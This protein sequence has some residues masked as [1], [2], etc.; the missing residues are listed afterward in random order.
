MAGTLNNTCVLLEASGK[1]QSHVSTLNLEEMETGSVVVA[2]LYSEV[3]GTDVHLRHGRLNT[4]PYPIIPGHVSVG[5]V[6]HVSGEV[7][8]VEGIKVQTGTLVTFLDVIG[9]CHTCLTCLVDKQTTRCPNRKVLGI[10][11]QSNPGSLKKLLGGWSTHIYL[12]PKTNIISLPPNLP[13]KVFMAGGCGLPTAFHAVERAEIRLMDRVVVQ[14]AGPVGLMA[15]IIAGLRGARQVIMVGGPKKRLDVVKQFG[16]DAVIDIQEI[17]DP[18]ARLAEIRRITDCQLA[19]VTIEATGVPSA[20]SEGMNFCKNGG[21]Y[22]VV[23]QYTDNGTVDI[24]PHLQI[25]RKHLSVKGCWG[26]DLSHFYRG[27]QLMEK[28]ADKFPWSLIVSEEFD[29]FRAEEALDAVESL[30]VFKA[31]IK[32]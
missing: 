11:C 30:N 21:T 22:V 13:P 26:S 32:P 6:K 17:P 5:T 9:T 2:V 19:D 4:V 10:T 8:D 16:I 15:A 20:V 27:V 3:C 1:V 7:Y 31:L 28:Y 12:P 25:N 18:S 23:G 14:G 29:L 24:N